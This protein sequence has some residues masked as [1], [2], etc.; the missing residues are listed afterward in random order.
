[1]DID[2]IINL[3]VDYLCGLAA[4]TILFARTTRLIRAKVTAQT[5]N[6][7]EATRC[8]EFNNAIIDSYKKTQTPYCVSLECKSVEIAI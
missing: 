7:C 3:Y 2:R 6:L 4:L 5:V 8:F 1:M